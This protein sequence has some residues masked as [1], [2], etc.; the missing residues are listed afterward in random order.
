[1][2]VRTK[3]IN[4]PKEYFHLA[5]DIHYR[6]LAIVAILSGNTGNE[7]FIVRS[8][9]RYPHVASISFDE[10]EIIDD[11]LEG[12]WVGTVFTR[13]QVAEPL[14]IVGSPVLVNDALR[15][16]RIHDLNE[17]Y[18]DLEALFEQ[19]NKYGGNEIDENFDEAEEANFRSIEAAIEEYFKNGPS[20]N[21]NGDRT[22]MREHAAEY[23]DNLRIVDSYLVKKIIGTKSDRQRILLIHK[24]QRFSRLVEAL[25]RVDGIKVP[26]DLAAIAEYSMDPL[27]QSLLLEKI[28]KGKINL[29]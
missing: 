2:L 8:E 11:T 3:S 14:S 9:D 18:G 10:L 15:Y 20:Y 22:Y 21:N 5:P 13:G 25:A 16:V 1:M 29:L 12:D 27:N 24:M 4:L 19:Y 17:E 23:L 28:M 26:Q 6:V 7:A